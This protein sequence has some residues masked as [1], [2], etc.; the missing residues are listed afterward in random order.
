[1][2]ISAHG[3]VCTQ[4]TAKITV[5][6]NAEQW[7]LAPLHAFIAMLHETTVDTDRLF[8]MFSNTLCPSQQPYYFKST[9]NATLSGTIGYQLD[10]VNGGG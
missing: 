8:V 7:L 10:H 5:L 3:L 9:S 1:M 4:A 6:S 2:A